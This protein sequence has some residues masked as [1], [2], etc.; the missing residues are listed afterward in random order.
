MEW[1]GMKK[2]MQ[3]CMNAYNENYGGVLVPC[4]KKTKETDKVNIFVNVLTTLYTTLHYKSISLAMEFATPSSSA[5][6]PSSSVL[7]L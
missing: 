3:T 2:I 4:D 1:N 6:P 5:S 7:Y